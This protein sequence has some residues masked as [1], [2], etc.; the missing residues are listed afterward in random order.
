MLNLYIGKLSTVSMDMADQVVERIINNYHTDT[1]EEPAGEHYNEAATNMVSAFLK[2][3]IEEFVQQHNAKAPSFSLESFTVEL[4]DEYNS[5][6]SA[7]GVIDD[8]FL[9]YVGDWLNNPERLAEWEAALEEPFQQM[10]GMSETFPSPCVLVNRDKLYEM[11][12]ERRIKF[13]LVQESDIEWSPEL[14]PFHTE[15]NSLYSTHPF[16]DSDFA[17]VRAGDRVFNYLPTPTRAHLGPDVTEVQIG[18]L[19]SAAKHFVENED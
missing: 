18:R 2:Q 4:D 13:Y 15:V 10:L 19:T 9:Q 12:F 6:Y 14:V 5:A 16:A 8:E 11:F 3:L 1:T 7:E 17:F